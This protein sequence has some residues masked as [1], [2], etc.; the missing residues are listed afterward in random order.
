M[1]KYTH[2][3]LSRLE[4][5]GISCNDAL[6]LRRISMTLHRWH[7]LECGVGNTVTWY[8]DRTVKPAH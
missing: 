4:R 2:K 6:A 7:E 8:V 5:S 1:N 3:M